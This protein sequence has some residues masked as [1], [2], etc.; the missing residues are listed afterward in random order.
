MARPKCKS[1][2]EDEGKRDILVN[3]THGSFKTWPQI[4]KVG[5]L[6]PFPGNLV[7]F[8][9]TVTGWVVMSES[10]SDKAVQLLPGHLGTLLDSPI[11]SPVSML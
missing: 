9:T 6:S 7:E 8:V 4:F 3:I 2:D 11:P 5:G 1:E 10:R